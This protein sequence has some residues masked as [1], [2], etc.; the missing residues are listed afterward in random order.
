MIYLILGG[1]SAFFGLLS[2]VGPTTLLR[3]CWMRFRRSRPPPSR[4][5][6]DGDAL[7]GAGRGLFSR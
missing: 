5:C 1:V 3:P 6:H 7:R 2:G 4:R